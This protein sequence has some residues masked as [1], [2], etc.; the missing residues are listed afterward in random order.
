MAPAKRQ[1]KGASAAAPLQGA[2]RK[3]TK[4]ERS[5]ENKQKWASEEGGRSAASRTKI[6]AP[7]RAA[8]CIPTTKKAADR[9]IDYD[10]DPETLPYPPEL[11]RKL[12]RLIATAHSLQDISEIEG[13]PEL[14]VLLHW[15]A[16][17]DHPF[18]ATYLKAKEQMEPFLEELVTKISMNPMRGV[19]KVRKQVLDKDGN[20]VTLEEER[21]SD[22]VERSRLA[23]DA[24]RWNLAILRPKRYGRQPE[25]P[26]EGNESL[27]ELLGAMRARNEALKAG[28]DE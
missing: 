22:A 3:K 12:F 24:L 8:A 1:Q 19:T 18:G 14:F 20:I 7:I 2:E 15:R 26:A 9:V 23:A 10:V 28:S 25:Q 11:D 27:K 17:K 13:M 5:V 4:R 21:E 16:T 6:L